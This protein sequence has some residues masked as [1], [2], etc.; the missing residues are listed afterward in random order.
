MSEYSRDL[1]TA[2]LMIEEALALIVAAALTLSSPLVKYYSRL[3][4]DVVSKYRP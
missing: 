4:M 3:L 1:A 2:S